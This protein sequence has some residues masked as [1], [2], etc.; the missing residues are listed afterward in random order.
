MEAGAAD[1]SRDSDS[2][3]RR[4]QALGFEAGRA[5]VALRRPSKLMTTTAGY[6]EKSLEVQSENPSKLA[7]CHMDSCRGRS[8]CWWLLGG[9]PESHGPR[10][11]NGA[12]C[13]PRWW[14]E[15]ATWVLSR[16]RHT[17]E[18]GARLL[19]SWPHGG[20]VEGV[21]AVPLAGVLLGKGVDDETACS[22]L[23]SRRTVIAERRDWADAGC[24]AVCFRRC[25]LRGVESA[26]AP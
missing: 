24:D 4:V 2:T 1:D 19:P 25:E 6:L 17:G 20:L 11:I 16:L 23:W 22:Y 5:K 14:G 3:F 7:G 12:P 15:P 10:L 26:P 13:G 9:E 18:P 21:S 8:P